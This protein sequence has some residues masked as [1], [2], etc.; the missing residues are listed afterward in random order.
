[1]SRP[2]SPNAV[3]PRRRAE[4]TP[5]G[6]ERGR[7]GIALGE[8]E[9]ADDGCGHGGMA[10]QDPGLRFRV[11]GDQLPYVVHTVGG[12]LRVMKGIIRGVGECVVHRPDAQ[13]PAPH[14][15]GVRIAAS[16]PPHDAERPLLAAMA[17]HGD[18]GSTDAAATPSSRSEAGTEV[19]C[20]AV[21]RAT[22]CSYCSSVISSPV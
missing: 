14:G 19:N 5:S 1:M 20:T 9:P 21:A 22:G 3:A 13:L 8:V 17:D 7:R 2:A 15:D 11:E 6:H 16:A 10:R 18:S 4:S 12:R